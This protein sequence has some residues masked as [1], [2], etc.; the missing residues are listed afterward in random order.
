MKPEISGDEP[1]R[2]A[3]CAA[4]VAQA[5]CRALDARQ[6]VDVLRVRQRAAAQHALRAVPRLLEVLAAL[7]EARRAALAPALRAKPVR[8]ASGVAVVAVMCRPHRCPH[9]AVTGG[10]CVYCPGGPDSDFEYST[11]AYTGYEPTSMRAVRARYHPALQVRARV[12]QLGA[13]GH[14]VDKVE[15][16]VMGGTFLSMPAAYREWFVAGLLDALSGY[17]SATLAEAVHMSERA[18]RKCVAVTIETRPDHC[19]RPHVDAMLAYGC[20]RVE[21][22]VQSVFED[23][24]RDTNRGHSVAAVVRSFALAKDAGYK[25]VTH[26]MPDL[27]QMGWERDLNGF[28]ERES[29]GP[30]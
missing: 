1:A 26:M 7:P 8:S 10:A 23:V 17:A 2:R 29:W 19:Q 5:L 20:T 18:R 4:A 16:I 30:V 24:A 13:L 11:Q 6:P 9:V 25:V 22:G 3:A 28:R 12:E 14:A 15:F 27:P 21:I